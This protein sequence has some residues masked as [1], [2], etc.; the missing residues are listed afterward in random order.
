M[1]IL[2]SKKKNPLGYRIAQKEE[3]KEKSV[4]FQK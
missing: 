4:E 1:W 3:E 2:G